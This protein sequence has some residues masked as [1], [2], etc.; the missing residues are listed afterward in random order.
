MKKTVEILRENPLPLYYQLKM[1]IVDQIKSGDLAEGKMLPSE[2]M[3]Q[4]EFG[5]SRA[6]VRQAFSEL[7]NEGF[8][9]RR[10]GIGTFVARIKV[11]PEINKLTSFTD[12]MLSRGLKP[13]SVVLKFEKII[14]PASVLENLGLEAE[15]PVWSVYRLRLADD[16]P[17]GLQILY[18]PP[19][20]DIQAEDIASLV[21]Y[22]KLLNDKLGL[23]VMRGHETLTARSATSREAELLQIEPNGPVLYIQRLSY[24]EQDKPVEYVEFIYRADRYQY[25]LS[26]YR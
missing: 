20:L 23:D 1:Q 21:S 9:E 6:T 4:K 10:Q 2:H 7:E 26:L 25:H 22:Y 3:Y 11:A 13:G 8:L 17:M 16:E 14:P 24:D 5:I 18:I 15:I 19:W 12:D